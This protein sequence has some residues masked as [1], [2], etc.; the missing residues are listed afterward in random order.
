MFN[1]SIQRVGFACKYMHTDQ[2]LPAKRLKE[3]QGRLTERGTTQQWLKRQ[4]LTDQYDRL[5]EIAK[6]NAQAAYNLVQ[7]VGGLPA[8]QRMVRLGSDQLPFYTLAPWSDFYKQTDVRD[9]CAKAYRRVG[10]LA[11]EMDVRLSMHP[12]QFTVLGSDRDDVVDRSIEELEYHADI[13]RWMGFGN[14]FQDFKINIHLA[15]RRG[16]A[17]F[18]SASTRL[19]PELCNMLTVENDEYSS[20]L[21]DILELSDKFA[22]V[23]DTHHHWI[24]SNEFIHPTDSRYQRVIESWRGVR[25]AMHYS[26]SRP[27]YLADVNDNKLPDRDVLKEAGFASTKIRAHSDRY[28]HTASNDMIAEFWPYAD[29]MAESKHKNLASTALYNYLMESA[30]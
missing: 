18:R 9:F 30:T 22:L 17:G 10:D 28:T 11:R 12:G 8:G 4:P 15:G 24:H 3:L 7:Y 21:D 20:G 1:Q 6:H 29:I 13:A 23:F 26:V 16:A 14:T 25:P 2:T 19:S 27:E 5:W